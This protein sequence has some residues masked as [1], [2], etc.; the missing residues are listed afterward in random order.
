[1]MDVEGLSA[2]SRVPDS[3]HKGV[4]NRSVAFWSD[5]LKSAEFSS[6]TTQLLKIILWELVPYI[7]WVGSIEEGIFESAVPF[8][9][10][11]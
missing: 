4:A 5:E 7:W 3:D 11:A 10:W 6:L 8:Y 2:K 9:F 1:M